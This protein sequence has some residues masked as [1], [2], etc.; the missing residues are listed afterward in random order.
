MTQFFSTQWTRVST[1]AAIT[2]LLAACGKGQQAAVAPAATDKP[3][4]PRSR[5]STARPFRAMRTMTT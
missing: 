5:S 2:I 1:V 4:T 3:A